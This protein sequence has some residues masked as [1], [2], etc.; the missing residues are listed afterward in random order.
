ML[1]ATWLKNRSPTRALDG[2]TPFE[3]R[4]GSPPSLKGLRVWVRKEDHTSP[5]MA[6]RAREGHFVG[7]SDT[8]KGI[9][10]YWPDR[11]A[12]TVERNVCFVAEPELK[13]A[14]EDI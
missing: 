10:V 7:Y 6:S 9:R 11:R 1:H 8:S 5:K 2:K 12:V 3:A 4:Y 13:V 14:V